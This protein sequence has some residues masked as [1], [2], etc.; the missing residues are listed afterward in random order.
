MAD[1]TEADQ[2]HGALRSPTGSFRSEIMKGLAIGGLI[3]AGALP[4][5]KAPSTTMAS[6]WEA[7]G[8]DFQSAL[9]KYAAR[10]G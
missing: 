4:G 8:G 10:V 1:D 9:S 7:I 5:P 2:P 6:D 3:M